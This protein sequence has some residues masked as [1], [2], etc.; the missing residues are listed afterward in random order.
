MS[1][2]SQLLKGVLEGCILA[3]IARE[4]IY[5]YELSMK[6]AE[7]GLTFVSEGS[8]YPVLLRMQKENLISG[9]LKDSPNGPKRKYYRLTDSGR[10]AL[11]EFKENWMDLKV[12]VDHILNQRSE[13]PDS[14][15]DDPSK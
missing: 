12:A 10:Q 11:E 3:V 15:R 2:K 8:I 7:Y 4:E 6:L 1:L 13:N 9:T 14:R 5:G